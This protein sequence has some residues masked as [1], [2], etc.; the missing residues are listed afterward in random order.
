MPVQ[1][2]STGTQ[3]ASQSGA[4]PADLPVEEAEKLFGQNSAF[5]VS[6]WSL[7]PMKFDWSL[8]EFPALIGPVACTA[9][10]TR[11]SRASFIDACGG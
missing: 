1:G 10:R 5:K 8:R 7:P 3:V 4:K 9:H 2:C 11:P 6:G